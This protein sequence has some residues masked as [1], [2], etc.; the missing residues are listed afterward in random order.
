MGNVHGHFGD[1]STSRITV[2]PTCGPAVP[3]QGDYTCSVQVS[4]QEGRGVAR[5]PV[6]LTASKTNDAGITEVLVADKDFTDEQGVAYLAVMHPGIAVDAVVCSAADIE[7]VEPNSVFVVDPEEVLPP[8]HLTLSL[9]ERRTFAPQVRLP[10]LK[11]DIIASA[12]LYQ[13]GAYDRPV[14]IPAPFNGSEQ[15]DPYTDVS[16]YR[17][18]NTFMPQANLLGLDVWLM[19]TTTGQNI[20]EQSAEFAQLIDYAARRLGPDGKIAVAG[21]SLGGVN[22][23]LT[24]A[25]YQADAAW[26]D[27]LGIL[28]TDLPVSLIAFGDAPLTGANIPFNLQSLIWTQLSPNGRGFPYSQLP[29]AMA[30]SNLNSCG[31]QQLLRK[32]Y[33][34]FGANFDRFWNSGDSVRFPNIGNPGGVCDRIEGNDCVCD[35]DLA[36]LSVNGDGWAHDIRIVAYADGWAGPQGCFGEANG[37]NLDLDRQGKDVCRDALDSRPFFPSFEYPIFRAQLP[38]ASDANVFPTQ[39][40]LAPGSR[41]GLA[42]TTE[43]QDVFGIPICGGVKKQYFG[44]TFIPFDSAIPSGPFARTWHTDGYQGVHGNS[45]R[46]NVAILFEEL[47]GA[48]STPLAARFTRTLDVAG[49]PGQA[50]SVSFPSVLSEG[51]VSASRSVEGPAL[52]P[53]LTMGDGEGYYNVDSTIETQATRD[54]PIEVCMSY[55]AAHFMDEARL[56]LYHFDGVV[57]ADVTSFR[58]SDANRVCGLTTSLSPFAILEPVN[59]APH[60]PQYAPFFVEA[61]GSAGAEV[62]LKASGFRDPDAEPLT[63]SWSENE[64]V[65]FEGPVLRQTLGF[66]SHSLTVTVRDPRGGAASTVRT[67]VV[68]DTTPPLVSATV[69]GDV[70]RTVTADVADSVGVAT[71]EILL[72]GAVL[73]Q[74]LTAPPYAAAWDTRL[75]ADGEHTISVRATDTS[76]NTAESATIV[77]SL[78]RTAPVLT[79][80]ATPST[81]WPPNKKL[82]PVAISITVQDAM[83]PSPTTIL[84]AVSCNDGC[85]PGNDIVG[86][87]IGADDRSIAVRAARSGSGSGRT[88][89]FTYRAADYAGNIV[90]T[91]VQVHVPHDQR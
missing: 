70:V 45:P 91:I 9:T 41:L 79:V 27:S 32:S 18:F 90:R 16:L 50:V 36:M 26:R 67:V 69:A 63:F 87:A 56:L 6:R 54:N 42:A 85:V 13:S 48:F 37:I 21:Y 60:A 17:L 65:L 89:F 30:K 52:P 82:V 22:S 11:N 5:V 33:P 7:T 14:V 8:Q 40:D 23:R 46:S 35:S 64:S 81:I 84:E 78:D 88:Y 51:Q 83:D 77:V 15:D 72:D 76:G 71:V 80:Q 62:S 12:R 57:W 47:D 73:G 44:P 20:H 29:Q 66:G 49:A 4:T 28:R 10:G 58:D 55:G 59:T 1:V 43:C 61:T 2:S 25:R 68:R 24:T 34:T 31:A 3:K 19:R 39:D 53:G 86:A 75:S 74:T 38:F